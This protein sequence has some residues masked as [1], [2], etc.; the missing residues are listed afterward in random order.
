MVCPVEL[1]TWD[2]RSSEESLWEAQTSE[3]STAWLAPGGVT[4]KLVLYVYK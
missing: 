1:V 3:E 4:I 2:L